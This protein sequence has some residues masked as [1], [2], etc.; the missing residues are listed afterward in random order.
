[1]KRNMM[2]CAILFEMI[3]PTALFLVLSFAAY[4]LISLFG[5]LTGG[6]PGSFWEDV[7][8][9][10]M[11]VPL[12]ILLASNLLFA[13]ALS[14]G[15]KVTPYAIPASVAVGIIA[16]FAYSATVLH[17][18][19]TPLKLFAIAIILVGVYLLR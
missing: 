14:H 12:L 17:A 2:P 18:S 15:F 19:V 1:M 8:A 9:V 6:G 4:L 13:A 11:P 16:S 10:F 3:L 7:R 5:H